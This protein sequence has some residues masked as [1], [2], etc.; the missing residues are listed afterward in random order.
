MSGL[1]YHELEQL[2]ADLEAVVLPETCVYFSVTRTPDQQGG[3][4]EAW[5]AAGTVAARL[6]NASVSNAGGKATRSDSVR[7]FASYMVTV[8]YDAGITTAHRVEIL[9][10]T[11]NVIAVSD[12]GSWLGV[13]RLQVELI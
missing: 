4:T 7:T 5:A 6:D 13:N 12:G 10:N 8:P 9:G 2:R 11:F 3:W 1:D